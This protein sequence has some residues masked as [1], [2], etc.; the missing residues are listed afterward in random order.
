MA[1]CPLQG[2]I[3]EPRKVK[4]TSLK[5]IM[6]I[7]SSVE[8]SVVWR[9][10]VHPRRMNN[11]DFGHRVELCNQ[12]EASSVM[13]AVRLGPRRS[14]P[15]TQILCRCVYNS[16]EHR[17]THW[18]PTRRTDEHYCMRMR[19]AVAWCASVLEDQFSAHG[20]SW[21]SEREGLVEMQK[22]GSHPTF[23]PHHPQTG[24]LVS[25]SCRCQTA[26]GS[27]WPIEHIAMAKVGWMKKCRPFLQVTL[28]IVQNGL[29][30]SRAYLR[31]WR[32]QIGTQAAQNNPKRLFPADSLSR[33]LTPL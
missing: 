31:L 3:L 20:R 19:E 30:L 5:T 27:H 29:P 8:Q 22:V 16:V 26:L 14:S 17:G 2:M 21:W 11:D 23:C 15:S 4:T 6:I 24:S 32:E 25:L 28:V 33:L 9:N 13:A 1:S 12:I 18:M 10:S 7:S